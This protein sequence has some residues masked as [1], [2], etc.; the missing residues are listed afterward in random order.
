MEILG[1]G[2]PGTDLQAR[3]LSATDLQAWWPMAR[4]FALPRLLESAGLLLLAAGLYLIAR[5]SAGRLERS[6]TLRTETE[7]DDVV[8]R[9]ARRCLLLSIAFWA[10][11]RL[12]HI[13]ELTGTSRLVAAMWIVALTLPIGAFVAD[14]LRILEERVVPRT[15]TRLDDTALPLLNKIARFL[16]VGAGVLVAL[17]YLGINVTPLL[18]GAGVLGLAVS[19]AAKDTLSNV[20]AGILLILDRPFQVGDRIEMWSTPAETGTWGDVREIG[21]RATKIRNP[22]NI[23]VVVPN[24]EIMKRDIVNYTAS[25]PDIRLRIPIGIAYDADVELAKKLMAE[26][27]LAVAGVKTHPEPVAIVRSFGDSA[28][29]LQLRIWI[30]DARRRRSVADEV[31]ERVKLAFDANGVEIPYP[32]RD[33]YVHTAAESPLRQEA[34]QPAEESGG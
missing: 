3:G 34:G 29:N 28:V 1:V 9:L 26:E 6:L 4:D 12:A 5:W 21:L 16:V 27:A 18:A 2:L 14:V 19:L 33:L 24:N 7:F 8:V 10:V 15:D 13:W 22:D 11:W 32:K 25:G 17:E 23:I 31:T 30:D 20:I